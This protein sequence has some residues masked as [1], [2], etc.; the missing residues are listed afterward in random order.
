[1][2]LILAALAA[3][4]AVAAQDTFSI[5]GRIVRTT[6]EGGI[7]NAIVQLTGG[8]MPAAGARQ[9]QEI[10]KDA[11]TAAD[12]S[13]R[14]DGIAAGHYYLN[15]HH[16]QYV[17]SDGRRVDP[18]VIGPSKENVRLRLT[19]L[20]IVEGVVTDQDGAPVE[21]VRIQ[22]IQFAVQAGLRR[23]MAGRFTLTDDRGR[24]RIAKLPAGEWFL[25]AGPAQ[26]STSPS[27]SERPP[28]I[29]TRVVP[30]A[31]FAGGAER[32]EKSI[33]FRL[34]LQPAARIAGTLSGH[35]PEE[36]VAF[37]LLGNDGEPT[38][39]YTFFNTRTGAFAVHD[40]LPGTYRLRVSQ[41]VRSELVVAEAPVSVPP[42]G[43]EGVRLT[44]FPA[45]TVPVRVEPP[46]QSCSVVLENAG[47]FP[48]NSSSRTST[49]QPNATMGQVPPGVYRIKPYCDRAYVA[50]IR[51]GTEDVTATRLI[52][53]PPGS[54][55]PPITISAERGG[56]IAVQSSGGSPLPAVAVAD[57]TAAAPQ[58]VHGHA[59][60]FAPGRY[61]V[62]ALPLEYGQVP[63]LE[64][65]YLRKLTGGVSV[66]VAAGETATV[67]LPEVRR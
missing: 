55:A 22:A 58:L 49:A 36:R 59:S 50:A 5:S 57:S 40:V 27:T 52:N 45:A 67:K 37:Q 26:W 65:E 33:D 25:R 14:F 11:I 32:I 15:A 64:P 10:H 61:T 13:F 51:F 46:T 35:V 1:M 18:L 7:G 47:G 60:N 41:W 19:P 3:L 17:P 9:F 12:G 53:V 28:A 48:F 43:L 63:Y 30:R 20:A 44:A 38:S 24:F 39:N 62:Y 66:T 56:G 31:M 23:Q 8:A 34:N 16:P 42:G 4:A 21:G 54:G 6:D 2:R 29:L